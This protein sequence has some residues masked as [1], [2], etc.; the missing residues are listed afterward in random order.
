ML[1]QHELRILQYNVQKSRDVVLASLFRDP[2]VLEYGILAIQEPWRNPFIATSYH[3]LKKHYQLTYMEDD[4]TRVC[5]YINKRIDPSTWRVSFISTDIVALKLTNHTLHN[6]LHIFNVYNEVATDTLSKLEEAIGDVDPADELLVL[7]DFNLHHP[8]W[9]K[10]HRRANQGIRAAQPLLRIVES[11]HL[12]LLTVPGTTT[13]RWAE[14]ESTIDLTFASEDIAS[15]LIHCRV[16]AQSDYDSDHLPIATSI[17]WRWQPATLTKKRM[18]TKTDLTLLRQAVQNKLPKMPDALTLSDEGGINEYVQSIVNALVA[19]IDASTPWSNPSSCSIPGFDKECKAICTEVQQLRRR[20]QRTRHEEDYEA[21]RQAR[22]RKGRHIQKTLRNTHRQKVEEASASESGLWKLVKW[23][24]NR[25]TTASACT[26]TLVKSD[27]GLAHEPEEKAEILRQTFFPPPLMADLSDIDGYEYPQAIECPEI[28]SSEIERAIRRAAPNK[29][30][31][32]DDIP[33]VILHQTLDILL[34]HLEKLFN[35]CLR[36]QY[37]PVHF[38]EAITVV[39]RKPG[40]DDYTQ[41][42]SYRP[43]ALLNTLGKALE[44]IIANR[45]TYL[46]DTYQLLP[47]RHTGGRKLASTDHAIHLLLQRIHRAWA[48]GKVASLLLLDVSGAFDN[49]SRRRLLHNLRKRRI[50]QSLVGWIDSFL[51]DRSSTLKLQEYT[52]PSA[53]IQTGIPQGSP[54]SPILYLFYNAD[55]I[56]ACKTDDTE[57]VGYIDDASI[58]AVGPT[59]QRNCKTLKIIHRRAEKWALQHGSQFAP[60]K[61]ELVHFSRDPKAN[62]THSLRLSHDTIK[63]TT[64]CRYL[65]IQ[66]DSRLRWDP[67]RKIV[68]TK[69]TKRL[70][71]LSA[72]ASSTWG[73]GLINLRQVYKAMVL[74]QVLYGCSA[75]HPFGRNE[76]GRGRAMIAT[77]SRIQKRAAQII[78]GA[79]RTTAG[80]AV[81]VEAQL[82]PPT[83]QL[84]QTALEAAMRIRTSPLYTEMDQPQNP[85]IHSPLNQLSE[86]LDRKYKIRLDQ[87]EKRQPHIVPPWWTP[88]YTRIAESPEMAIQE[89]NA[90]EQSTLCF[91]TDGSGI[92]GHVGAAAVAPWVHIEEVQTKRTAY[93][94]ISTTSTVYAAELRGMELAF[95]IALDI[96]TKTNTPDKCVIFADSQAAIQAM[97]NP[98]CP[99]GQ[100]ILAEAIQALDKLRER[101]WEIQIRW[102]PAH[103]GVPGNEIAD[104]AAKEAAG[105]NPTGGENQDTQPEHAPPRIL[106]ATTKSS[107][108][109]AMKDEWEQAWE[110]SEHG[111]DLFRLGVR[112]GKGV[113][114]LHNSTHRAISSVITQMRT[115]KISLRAYLHHIN[116]ADTDQCQCSHGRQT[117]RHILL[118]CRNWMDER[119][120]MWAG[121]PPCMDI[122]SVLCNPTMAVQAAKMM[123]RTGL[124]QQFRAVP[125]RALIYT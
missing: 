118:E 24:K 95:Q 12:Q 54:L 63:A 88:P 123:I 98:K 106:T 1:D 13:R 50:N 120:R 38:K 36:Q 33:N 74:P 28:T 125:S 15:R 124:L 72:L 53:P 7:G 91:Y 64:S 9:S 105:H 44:A 30:P 21:Y 101:G 58:L 121:K 43:I 17:D 45:L 70:S 79:F 82:L 37:C 48:E 32:T 6:Q 57:A 117:V 76:R 80:D 102:I 2:K 39:L 18:W 22:N 107:I 60:A 114:T 59:A 16:D 83:Q 41:P 71:A 96:Y 26:P 108:R 75:W 20:W 66:M 47:K 29:A 67:H 5:F 65:G 78:T 116:K 77:V 90:I 69:A 8:L 4:N 94:G 122:K 10:T 34:P 42:K 52:A 62:T 85:N 35:T 86:I 103:V 46:V 92:D 27:G 55:L 14:G 112:P 68:E 25:H 109:R 100:Y 56:E 104:R 119:H 89:H 51:S 19:G 3:P 11:F 99:S 113:L 49:V 73:T 23:A 110:N 81:D 97:A 115:A 40:K 93:M 87:L 111:R 31:G 84:E 61:Y